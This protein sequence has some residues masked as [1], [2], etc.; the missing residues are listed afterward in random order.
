MMPATQLGDTHFY[1]FG[2]NRGVSDAV[3]NYL[4]GGGARV[5]HLR[6]LTDLAAAENSQNI[7]VVHY[8]GVAD[9][10][11]LLSDLRR[12]FNP[13]R[14]LLFH[15]I[16]DRGKM[17]NAIL[18][19][20]DHILEKPFPVGALEKALSQFRFLPLSGKAIYVYD[21]AGSAERAMMKSLGATLHGPGSDSALNFELAVFAPE[22]L[23]KAFRTE[24]SKFRSQSTETPI[25]LIY[26]PRGAG[27]L[28]AEIL[29][30][31]AYLIQAPVD[32][33]TFRQKVLDY[34]EQPQRDRRKNPRKR[35]ISQLWVS[36]FNT[37]LN[38]P[39]LFESPFLVDV[40]QSGVSFQSRVEYSEGQLMAVWVV[41]EDLPDKILDL[42]GHIRWRRSE[43]TDT[44]K[45]PQFKYGLE[46]LKEQ[47]EA[48]LNFARMVAMH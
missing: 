32:K 24:L 38:T 33:G 41:S 21:P 37:E 26:D 48:Y 10:A 2:E 6:R 9:Q 17:D 28:D 16:T 1:L 46:F 36:S 34:F 23:N 39:E 14:I 42:R 4:L 35:G 8:A 44:K 27:M 40:S 20:S 25:F 3:G 11:A 31:I 30:E 5:T 22:A 7:L 43:A 18:S 13:L 29:N 12:K 45:S 19:A 15:E 47:S